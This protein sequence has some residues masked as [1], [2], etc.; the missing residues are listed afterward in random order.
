[1]S[2]ARSSVADVPATDETDGTHDMAGGDIPFR[3]QRMSPKRV[4]HFRAQEVKNT[5]LSAAQEERS[6]A[7]WAVTGVF[8]A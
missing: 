2:V 8:R 7:V 1:M 4:V 3:Q 5:E 6:G